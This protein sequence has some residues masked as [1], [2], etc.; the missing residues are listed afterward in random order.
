MDLIS[1]IGVCGVSKLAGKALDCL[2]NGITFDSFLDI[3]IDKAFD[4]M[5]VNTLDLFLNGRKDERLC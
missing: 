3:L 2:L 4:F 5:E 1:I